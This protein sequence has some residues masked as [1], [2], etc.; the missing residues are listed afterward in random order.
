MFPMVAG[1]EYVVTNVP[2]S[3][4]GVGEW[5]EELFVVVLSVVLMK[6][7]NSFFG[8]QPSP[9]ER[10]SHIT[11]VDWLVGNKYRQSDVSVCVCVWLCAV[12]FCDHVNLTGFV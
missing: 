12:V 4:F 8:L 9:F 7:Q 1:G 6:T 2:V 11:V 3:Q 10:V 5:D